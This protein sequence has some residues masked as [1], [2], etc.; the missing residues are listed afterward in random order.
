[1]EETALYLTMQLGAALDDPNSG[2]SL[3]TPDFRTSPF[4]GFR[5]R[6]YKYGEAKSPKRAEDAT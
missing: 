2:K 3:N 1:M 4:R 6:N 5:A